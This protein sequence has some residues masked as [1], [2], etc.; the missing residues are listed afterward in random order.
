MNGANKY[1]AI[2]R[3]AHAYIE[4]STRRIPMFP[5]AD[6]HQNRRH[7]EGGPERRPLEYRSKAT[8]FEIVIYYRELQVGQKQWFNFSFTLLAFGWLQRV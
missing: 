8:G 4:P 5:K 1:G 2:F 3:N 6:L 7:C